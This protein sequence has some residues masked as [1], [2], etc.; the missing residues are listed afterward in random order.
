MYL[1][2]SGDKKP[3]KL[4]I[5]IKLWKNQ[6]FGSAKNLSSFKRIKKWK[7]SEIKSKKFI[8][9]LKCFQGH[10]GILVSEIRYVLQSP[11]L[12]MPAVGYSQYRVGWATAVCK[13][14]AV[15]AAGHALKKMKIL[16]SILRLWK[17]KNNF[18]DA[19][20]SRLI[21]I[22]KK[23]MFSVLFLSLIFTEASRNHD[24]KQD[25][26]T[27]SLSEFLFEKREKKII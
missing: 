6:N 12:H 9:S 7:R 18:F 26:C 4:L 2:P 14:L 13:F 20:I 19:L 5:I 8:T 27:K 22:Q 25:G 17:K 15:N 24:E 23:N 21:T 11:V 3:V 10:A 1:T 16:Q